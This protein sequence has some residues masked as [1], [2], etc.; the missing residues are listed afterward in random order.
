MATR[1]PTSPRLRAL[2][3]HLREV[4]ADTV[5]AREHERGLT[6]LAALHHQARQLQ[7]SIDAEVERLESE[8]AAE[9]TAPTMESADQVLATAM[10]E[11]AELPEHE[12]RALH[13][14]IGALLGLA[15]PALRVVGDE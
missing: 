12:R 3:K 5:T 15:P 13:T 14:S 6:A 9:L 2:R 7:D 1:A 11:A 10:A 4:R 8:A